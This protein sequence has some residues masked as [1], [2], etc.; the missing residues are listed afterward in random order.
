MR[1]DVIILSSIV[2]LFL[3]MM[4]LPNTKLN[5][6]QIK[7]FSIDIANICSFVAGGGLISYFISKYI[8]QKPLTDV[9]KSLEN[10]IASTNESTAENNAI[11]CEKS[12]NDYEKYYKYGSIIRLLLQ[13]C[14]IDETTIIRY[15]ADL[16]DRNFNDDIMAEK[17]LINRGLSINDIKLLKSLSKKRIVQVSKKF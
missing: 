7:N 16:K 12:L 14:E 9:L 15:L 8:I 1:R 11:K 3:L 6:I 17:A 10:N 5:T 4:V 2:I 13:G